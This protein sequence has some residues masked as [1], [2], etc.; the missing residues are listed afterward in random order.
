MK[1]DITKPWV[2]SN[3]FWVMTICIHLPRAG[4]SPHYD[5]VEEH[6]PSPGWAHDVEQG[7]RHDLRGRLHQ[8]EA[9]GLQRLWHSAQILEED[10]S[11]R[12]I[13]EGGTLN[14]QKF[15]LKAFQWPA[16]AT[17]AALLAPRPAC[18]RRRRA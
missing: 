2:M 12:K 9:I 6:Q 4:P 5:W 8:P 7:E 11:V 16:T 17:A 15:Q 3:R 18:R 1:H 10:L 14:S 13:E